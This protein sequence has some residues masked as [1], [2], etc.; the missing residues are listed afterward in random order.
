MKPLLTVATPVLVAEFVALLVVGPLGYAIDGRRSLAWTIA[1]TAVW[2]LVFA[3]T[4]VWLKR[5]AL[6]WG[7]AGGLICGTAWSFGYVVGEALATIS[8]QSYGCGGP[9]LS[10][11]S[12]ESALV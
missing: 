11:L 4:A 2:S 7:V 3:L 6:G 1:G 9:R 12:A 10:E 5:S 8:Y